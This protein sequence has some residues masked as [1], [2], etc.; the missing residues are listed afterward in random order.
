VATWDAA[1]RDAERDGVEG[2]LEEGGICA[3]ASPAPKD[4]G[5]G[6]FYRGIL[7]RQAQVFVAVISIEGDLVAVNGP[8]SALASGVCLERCDVFDMNLTR[9]EL[10]NFMHGCWTT[11][12]I[13]SCLG[14]SAIWPELEFRKISWIGCVESAASI[15]FVRQCSSQLDGL[16]RLVKMPTRRLSAVSKQRGKISPSCLVRLCPR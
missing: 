8:V 11:S 13:G 12:R 15:S 7:A 10:M 4:G 6:T 1:Y 2:G 16:A 14:T 9:E 5:S 3:W